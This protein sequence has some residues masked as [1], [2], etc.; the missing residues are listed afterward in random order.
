MPLQIHR[1]PAIKTLSNA[2]AGSNRVRIAGS[3][4]G[5]ITGHSNLT[6]NGSVLAVTGA[7]S[8]TTVTLGGVA[9]TAT[10]TEINY[11][12]GVTSAIQTQIDAKGATAGSGNIVTTGA[13]NSGSITSGFGSID[14]GSSTITTTGALSSGDI[15]CT[16]GDIIYGNGQNGTLQVADTAHNVA[17]KALTISAGAST[18][19]TTNDIAGADL[20]LE[21][22]KGKGEGTT[23]QIVLKVPVPEGSS[24][25]TVQSLVTVQTHKATGSSTFWGG[26]AALA[27]DTGVGDIVTFGVEDAIN[28]P[29]AAGRLCYLDTDGKWQY[30]DADAVATGGTQ[31]LGIALGGAVS[32]GILIRGFFKLNS[33]VEGTWNEGIPCYV[34]EAV[35]EID[36]TAP[37]ASADFVRVVG[38]GTDTSGVIYFNPSS[39]NIVIA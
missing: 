13:L 23:G 14:I 39:T 22:G 10:G 6:F 28:S 5:G 8:S 21:G 36:F 25:S 30:T 38:Y 33:Y 17:S 7:L 34:S 26:T 11:I 16:G 2:S 4:T 37:N 27:N 24:N 15:T 35:S 29:L 32:D 12:D 1:R 9:I 20:T 19:G 18:A 3:A 31:L